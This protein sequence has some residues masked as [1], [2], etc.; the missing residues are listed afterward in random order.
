M[1]ALL[2]AASPKA[3]T[4]RSADRVPIRYEST[5][6]GDTAIVFVHGWGCDRRFWDGQVRVFA[7][8]YR[9]VTLDLAGH[10]DS[11]R[12]RGQWTIAAF[13]ED[14]KA[15]VEK[16]KLP[17]VVL[18]GH[19]L[20]GP[21]I[22][23]AARRMPQRV[24]GLVPVD[25]LL[26][27]EQLPSPELVGQFVAGLE[28]DYVGGV[29]RFATDYLFAA[30]TPEHV[31]QRVLQGVTTMPPAQSIAI[32]RAAWE[33]DAIPA[34]GEITAPLRAI[35]ADKAPTNVAGNRR[36]AGGYEAH[37]VQGSGHYPMLEAPERFNGLL[38]HVLRGMTTP[39]R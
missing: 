32:L 33:Y 31:R 26:D 37:F 13:G 8:D 24:R 12:N 4:V 20:G 11:G 9:V 6:R 29:T 7:E 27:I 18:V 15:V 21:V 17:H 25:I 14:V 39:P 23:E 34:L 38:A 19:S 10:G 3:G 1:L 2:A 36:H 30:R 35:N 16:L 5:G 22:L 28:K